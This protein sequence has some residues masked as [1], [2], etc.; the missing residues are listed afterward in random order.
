MLIAGLSGHICESCITQGYS[1]V[2]EEFKANKTEAFKE[3]PLNILKPIEIKS[4][5]DE[6][7]I[8]Q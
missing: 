4:K 7:E 1:I 6:S 8:G 5:L 3:A 2:E